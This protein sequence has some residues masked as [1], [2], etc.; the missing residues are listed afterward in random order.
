M[1]DFKRIIKMKT[2][3]SVNKAIAAYEKRE[4]KS[5]EKADIAQDK[6][7]VKKAFSLH[8]TQQH[9]GK[10]D[11]SK[12]KKG[13]RAKKSE[14]TVRKYK[15][16][17]TVTN[18]YEAKKDAGDKDN[19]RKV[20]NIKPKKLQHGGLLQEPGKPAHSVAMKKGGKV[21]KYAEGSLVDRGI[22]AVKSFGRDIKENILGTPEQNRKSQEMLDKQAREGSKL[23]KFFGGK[24]EE[25]CSGGR[26]RKKYAEGGSIND[27]VRARAMKWLESGSPEQKADA[28]SAPVAKKS[29][30]KS[31][32]ESD[33]EEYSPWMRELR[34]KEAEEEER[35]RE[36]ESLF[37]KKP[38]DTTSKADP[39]KVRKAYIESAKYAKG[40]K[41]GG[42]ACK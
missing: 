28:P 42:K 40:L 15:T 23:A 18:V 7:I 34:K 41:R 14:G 16:G 33:R 2:G 17:G 38:V 19:I 6:K 30:P 4:R 9:E 21:K 3:G 1:D 32:P 29:A 27:D 13:G 20:K 12:L 36:S 35:K 25:K 5:E 11:L 31:Q 24:A 22:E 8:D 26:M 37:N 39:E 10:T